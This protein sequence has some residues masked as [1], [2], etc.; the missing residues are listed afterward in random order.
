MRGVTSSE[1]PEKNG[2]SVTLGVDVVAVPVVVVVETLVTKNSSVPT[3]STAFWLF[4]V[5]IRGLDSTCTLP[6]DSRKLSSAAKLLV[7]NAR[8]NKEPAACPAAAKVAPGMDEITPSVT[9][10]AVARVAPGD[11]CPREVRLFGLFLNAPQFTPDWKLSFNCTSTILA[12]SI[13]CRSMEICEALR[14]AVT[15]FNSSGSARTT[16]TPDIGLITTLRP[17]SLPTIAV[18]ALPSSSQKSV[19]EFM[20]TLLLS[21]PREA[22]PVV[23]VVPGVPPVGLSETEP[24]ETRNEDSPLRCPVR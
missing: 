19:L 9:A 11:N 17:F 6:C 5:A 14:Y 3:F 24:D 10:P 21:T 15:F 22:C 16:I 23:V 8:P 12:S 2:C 13:T 1:I 4:S 7:W 20:L 18:N